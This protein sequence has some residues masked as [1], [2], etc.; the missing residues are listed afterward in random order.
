MPYKIS[1]TLSDAARIIVIK[2]SDWSIESNTTE[3]VGSYEITGLTPGAKLVQGRKSDGESMGYGSVTPKYSVGDRGL[4]AGST[5]PVNTIEYITISSAGNSTDFGDLMVARYTLGSTSNGTI[6]RGIFAGGTTGAETNIIDYI[7]ISS[8]GDATDFGDLAFVR[9]EHT[10]TSNGTSNRGV[11]GGGKTGGSTQINNI[12]YITISST[13]NSQDFG[14]LT[15]GRQAFGATSN[16]TN[17]RG[18]FAGGY[19]YTN[20]IDYITISSAA[21]AINFGDLT[22]TRYINDTGCSNGTNE[23]GLFG[24]GF[25][26]SV[27]LNIID[28]ITISS[29]GNAA[30]FG[31]LTFAGN[32]RTATDNGVG[33]RGVWGGGTTGAAQNIMDYVTISS[34]GN[35]LDF[36]DLSVGKYNMTSTSNA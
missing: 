5:G 27:R 8:I 10:G 7:T 31:D 12:D 17:D 29:T 35:A 18:V 20:V 9:C 14:D 3:S 15:L 6:D 21:N 24:S 13:G 33:D 30:D 11:F 32:G 23:R 19:N 26:S 1:G 16:A 34:I 25:D 22:G 28:Y 2:E 36:G 4:F